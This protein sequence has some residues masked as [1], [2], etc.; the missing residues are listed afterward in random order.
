MLGGMPSSLALPDW[1]HGAGFQAKAD[2]LVRTGRAQDFSDAC[3]Q[4][5]KRRSNLRRT[6]TP[7]PDT[8]ALSRLWYLRE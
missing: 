5:A 6:A 7:P 1:W 2:W 3:K 8:K 4:L